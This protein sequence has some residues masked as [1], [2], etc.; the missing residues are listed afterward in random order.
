MAKR[1]N[2]E[3]RAK[4]AKRIALSQAS[5]PVW[6]KNNRDYSLKVFTNKD[7]E[8]IITRHNEHKLNVQSMEKLSSKGAT[9]F[10]DAIGN[11]LKCRVVN[12]VDF[13]Y[14]PEPKQPKPLKGLDRSKL[15]SI[16]AKRKLECC[17]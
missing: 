12:K 16:L 3:R 9:V 15:K 1:K 13:H 6:G 17:I 5:V 4:E 10:K 14:Y 8:T 11:L 7:G 2:P